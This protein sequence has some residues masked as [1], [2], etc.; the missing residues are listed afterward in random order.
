MEWR[1]LAQVWQRRARQGWRPRRTIVLLAIG[2]TVATVT[3][4]AYFSYR[5]LHRSILDNFK[6]IAL[7]KVQQ[8]GG[9]IDRWLATR[10]AEIETI[11]NAPSMVTAN[12]EQVRPY[13]QAEQQR[14]GHYYELTLVEPNGSYYS[15]AIGQADVNIF[16][17][18]HF[19]TAMQGRTAVSN[20]LVHRVTGLPIVAIAAPIA[21]ENGQPVGV[22]TGIL[23]TARVSNVLSNLKYGRGSY[24]FVVDR[25]GD[26]VFHPDKRSFLPGARSTARWLDPGNIELQNII[27]QTM[28]R[29]SGIESLPLNDRSVYLA[30]FP[31]NEVDWS[32][33]LVIPSQNLESE[34]GTLYLFSI[35]VG[36][37]L[38]IATINAVR[39]MLS[40]EQARVLAAREALLNR[41]TQRIRASLE[42]DRVVQTTV[43]EVVALLHLERAVFGWHD[44]E[45]GVL[46]ILWEYDR[47]GESPHCGRFAL[48]GDLEKK[49]QQGKPLALLAKG[50]ETKL[51][52]NLPEHRYLALP[53][54]PQNGNPGYFICI[55]ATRWFWDRGDR[56]MLQAVA[57]Q[58]ALA[59][60]QSHLYEQTQRQ[61]K[62]LDAALMEI[63]RTQSHL[64]Q[65]EKMSSLGQMVAGIAHELNN[66]VNFIHGNVS[67]VSEYVRDLLE[68]TQLYRQHL[69]SLPTE[70]VEFEEEIELDFLQE[71]VVQVLQSMHSGSDRI[72]Q[73][74]LSLRNFA[75]LDEAE[76]KP[77]NLHEGIDSTLQL[78]Q[79]R[80]DGI[81][82]IKNY[83]FLPKVECY[84]GQINQVFLNLIANAADALLEC[85]RPKKTILI[86]TAVI[87]NPSEQSVYIAIADNGSGI[88]AEVRDKIFD[89][90]FTTKPPGK[91]TGLGLSIAY[92]IVV[93]LHGGQI[94]VDSSDGGTEFILEFPVKAAV[95]E[96]SPMAESV[97]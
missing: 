72:R 42:L 73:I 75:R 83:G 39:Q 64:V 5:F 80:L 13:L 59:I 37:L 77:V 74:V 87:P 69:P 50:A 35:V 22:A 81:Q 76:K 88:P 1:Q 10:K 67:H 29:R 49:L 62:M 56:E 23:E 2:G 44:V 8:G 48:S 18:P 24:A 27:E 16:D 57:D 11:A 96:V 9:E 94:K 34:L 17:R 45:T 46:D 26:I 43:E 54:Q 41:L 38:A 7:L 93:D 70:V 25:E 52:L 84:A 31:L 14:L 91:G 58:L 68:L 32:I 79:H 55:H 40:G 86:S 85:D 53:V 66:P 60:N 71:D 4:S 61:V 65:T 6:A 51:T 12:W 19:Q 63:K 97:V 28:A 90:F 78:L 92:Q 82:V 15:T 21:A 36:I 30:Y 3:V 89:P 33:V 20:P 95:P 47:E